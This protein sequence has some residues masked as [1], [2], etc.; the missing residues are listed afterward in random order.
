VIS[1]NPWKP[2]NVTCK[3][4][5]EYRRKIKKLIEKSNLNMSFS[6]TE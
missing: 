1:R 2:Y 3:I 6:F 4:D 5:S